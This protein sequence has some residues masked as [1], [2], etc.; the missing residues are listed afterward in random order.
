MLEGA[1]DANAQS[2]TNAKK[3]RKRGMLQQSKQATPGLLT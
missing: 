3:P 2:S 1:R